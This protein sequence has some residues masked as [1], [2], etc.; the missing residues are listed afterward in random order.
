MEFTG[1]EVPEGTPWN[2]G[3]AA[4][5]NGLRMFPVSRSRIPK[6][7]LAYLLE[8]LN[9]MTL[10][11]EQYRVYRVYR[12]QATGLLTLSNNKSIMSLKESGTTRMEANYG[13]EESGLE[14]YRLWLYGHG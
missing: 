8:Q 10:A 11:C 2:E 9:L 12:V 3:R 13:K 1:G 14:Q 7:S 6:I 5:G 4:A